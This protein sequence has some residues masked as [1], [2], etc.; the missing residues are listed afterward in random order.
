MNAAALTAKRRLLVATASTLIAVWFYVMASAQAVAHGG[1]NFA[2]QLFHPWDSAFLTVGVL[3]FCIVSGIAAAPVIRRGTAM[4]RL[5]AASV[6]TLPV[7]MLAHF[8][9]VIAHAAIWAVRALT[10]S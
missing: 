9:F 10:T 7:F 6:L 1:Y 5:G 8:L 2:P 3:F 4:Q